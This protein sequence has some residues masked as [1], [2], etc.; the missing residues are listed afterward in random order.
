MA[1]PDPPAPQGAAGGCGANARL[2]CYAVL[3]D[4]TK[5]ET[6]FAACMHVIGTTVRMSLRARQLQQSLL[7]LLI[8]FYEQFHICFIHE[9]ARASLFVARLW[10]L[11]DLGS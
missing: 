8:A 10:S 5:T 11:G 7:L 9:H 4:A 1:S 2:R 3:S 6:A